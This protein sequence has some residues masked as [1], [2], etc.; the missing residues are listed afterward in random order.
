[1]VFRLLHFKGQ[2]VLVMALMC[3]DR[4]KKNTL[5]GCSI[6]NGGSVLHDITSHQ[7]FTSPQFSHQLSQHFQQRLALCMC[8]SIM[9]SHNSLSK[10]HY[11]WKQDSQKKCLTFYTVLRNAVKFTVLPCLQPSH[12]QRFFI[13]LTFQHTP[14]ADRRR[15]A[16]QFAPFW[17]FPILHM[18]CP[19]P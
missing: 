1:M 13:W 17:C 6:V 7:G 15:S 9:L 19:Q 11:F 12:V 10:K 14:T 4:Y 3:K 5:A 16:P 2:C 18:V 8:R